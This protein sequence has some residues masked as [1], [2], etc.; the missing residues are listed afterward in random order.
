MRRDSRMSDAQRRALS[1]LWPRFGADA[2][3]LRDPATLFG[4]EAPLHVEIGFGTGHALLALA[5]AHPEYNVLGIDVYRAGAGQVMME[6][7]RLGV[8]NLRIATD[9]AKDILQDH[10][11][12]GALAALYVFFPDPWPKKR[13]H[14]R[15]LVNAEFAA[16]A[17][18]KL[19]SGG[20]WHLATDWEEYAHQMVEVLN[21]AAGLQN[22]SPDG[23][24]VARPDSRPL[25]KFEKRGQRLGHAVFDLT[26]ERI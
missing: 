20:H 19:A 9:D 7:A 4:R 14:K 23:A 11:A 1:E 15:R 25:T 10:I 24:F 3:A 16:L 2:Q 12:D 6:A 26:F 22:L 8:N 5:Q 13:H 21:A 17:T 18:R